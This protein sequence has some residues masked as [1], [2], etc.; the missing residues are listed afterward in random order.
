MITKTIYKWLVSQT[1]FMS[2]A[3]G[4][5][6]TAMMGWVHPQTAVLMSSALAVLAV[7]CF[8]FGSQVVIQT[9]SEM[10]PEE[11]REHMKKAGYSDEHIEK[12]ME[13]EDD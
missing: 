11:I 4:T 3:T 8:I 1:L 7:L 13:D 6:V 12:V 9:C 10:T 5:V 2:L